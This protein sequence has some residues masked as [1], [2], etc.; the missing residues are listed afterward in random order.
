MAEVRGTCHTGKVK[1]TGADFHTEGI[2]TSAHL[3]DKGKDR[4]RFRNDWIRGLKDW[5]RTPL[6][7]TYHKS[8]YW[9]RH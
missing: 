2:D 5:L 1:S 4:S 9:S 7:G 3:T 6:E 8:V